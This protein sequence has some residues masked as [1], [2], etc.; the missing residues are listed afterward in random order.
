[1]SSSKSFAVSLALLC[2]LPAPSNGQE[3]YVWGQSYPTGDSYH[4]PDAQPSAGCGNL[5]PKRAG[6][7]PLD[8]RTVSPY[9]IAFVEVRHFTR[10]VE[11]LQRGGIGGSVGADLEYTLGTFPNHPRALRAAAEYYRR[12]RGLTP[13]YMSM[14]IECWFDRAI[15]YRKDDGDVRVVYAEHLLKTG[16]KAEAQQQALVA[17]SL[18]ADNARVHY[19]VGLVFFDLG[20]FDRARLHAHKASELGF[21][22]PG[23]AGKLKK[24]G[25]WS[26]P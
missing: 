17:E 10:Q 21:E 13:P 12:N 9:T 22:L 5:A 6:L 19:N 20:D 7:G 2:L 11:Q 15:A 16:K 3:A 18:A 24:A 1:M 25:K 23:L 26:D 4:P 8:Y 14:S